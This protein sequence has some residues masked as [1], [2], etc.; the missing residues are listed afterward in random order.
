MSFGSN[1]EQI[2]KAKRVSQTMLGVELGLTQQMI[3]SYEKDI[4][5]PNIEVLIKI[6]DYFNVSIDHLVG[7][8]TNTFES[9]TPNARFLRYFETLNDIDRE[10]CITIAHTLLQDRELNRT[11]SSL[12]DK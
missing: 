9:N 11:T 5:S 6:A 2:R 1:L 10:K 4:S 12:K 8:I 3:S 7:H